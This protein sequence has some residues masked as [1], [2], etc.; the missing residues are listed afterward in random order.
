[1]ISLIAAMDENNG[2]G[3]NNALL[4]HLPADLAFFK[5]KTM[6]KPMIMG[7]RTFQSIGSPLPGRRSIV[8]TSQTLVIPGVEIVH[9]LAEALRLCAEQPEIMVIGGSTLFAQCLPLADRIY[10]T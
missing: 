3:K 1:M 8:L 5:A 10:V 4:C 7:R 6:G 2:I 9:D